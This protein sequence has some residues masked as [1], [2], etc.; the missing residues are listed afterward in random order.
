M[1]TDLGTPVW[2]ERTVLRWVSW[3]TRGLAAGLGEARRRELASD[4]WEHTSD[5][6]STGVSDLLINV[7]VLER[8]VAGVPSDLSWRRAHLS[9][10]AGVAAD[11]KERL[12]LET[13][14]RSWWIAVVFVLAA[15]NALLAALIGG[16][17]GF[18]KRWAYVTVGAAVALLL[19][20]LVLRRRARVTGDVAVVIGSI[21]GALTSW[22]LILPMVVGVCVAVGAILDATSGRGRTATAG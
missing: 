14:K 4:L 5:G 7:E 1:T 9:A 13:L 21:V 20:G 17:E 12:M 10:A 15:W 19:G 8:M 22:W 16:G 11:G 18:D 3:Y 6:R 2:A